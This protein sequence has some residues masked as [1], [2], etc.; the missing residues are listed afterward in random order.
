MSDPYNQYPPQ[1]PHYSSPAPSGGYGQPPYQQGY[2][3]GYN[4]GY[5]PQQHQYGQ[6]DQG[7]G[8]PRRQD[9]YGPPAAGGF[10]H[11]QEGGQF[12]AYDASNPQGHAGY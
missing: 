5:P 4:Q 10:Q 2:D 7:F 9:S 12:G 11:G 8:P 1:P 3:Q 6:P